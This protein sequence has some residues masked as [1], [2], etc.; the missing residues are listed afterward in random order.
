MQGLL[1]KNNVLPTPYQQHSCYAL[2]DQ[3]TRFDGQIQ[4]KCIYIILYPLEV[5]TLI[6]HLV[7]QIAVDCASFDLLMKCTLYSSHENFKI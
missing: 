2:F 4:G 5:E 6:S 7:T 3:V 1:V